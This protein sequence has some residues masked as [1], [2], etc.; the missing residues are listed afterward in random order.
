M[1]PNGALL[2]VARERRL[3]RVPSEESRLGNVQTR[4]EEMVFARRRSADNVRKQ[5]KDEGGAF[6]SAQ[7]G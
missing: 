1:A 3:R 5:G 2:N 7:A 6:E 4:R